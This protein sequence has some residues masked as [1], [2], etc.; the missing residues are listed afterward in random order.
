MKRHRSF[1]LR[2]VL[3]MQSIIIAIA[4]LAVAA[5]FL[6]F[7]EAPQENRKT[8]A[9]GQIPFEIENTLDGQTTL[10][11]DLSISLKNQPYMPPS[12]IRKKTRLIE[13][14]GAF[15]VIYLLGKNGQITPVFQRKTYLDKDRFSKN[16]SASIVQTLVPDTNTSEPLWSDAFISPVTDMPSS[17]CIIPLANHLLVGEIRLSRLTEILNQKPT[18][19][20]WVALDKHNHVVA[21]SGGIFE[22]S[23]LPLTLSRFQQATGLFKFKSHDQPETLRPIRKTSWSVFSVLPPPPLAENI[24][25][26]TPLFLLCLAT[27]IIFSLLFSF[28]FSR[29]LGRQL[30][31]YIKNTREIARGHSPA[32][33]TDAPIREMAHLSQNLRKMSRTIQEKG[34]GYSRAMSHYLD[35]IKTIENIT[36]VLSPDLVITYVNEASG[37]IFGLEPEKCLGRSFLEFVKPDNIETIKE[38]HDR[39]AKQGLESVTVEDK[40]IDSSG[41]AHTVLWNITLNRDENDVFTG[42]TGVG[43]EFS[44]WKNM[45]EELQ[46]A[47]LV[48]QKSSEGMIL[49]NEENLII[50]VNPAF[51]AITGYT[52]K[53]ALFSNLSMLGSALHDRLFYENIWNAMDVADHWQGEAWNMRKN[54]ERYAIRLTINTIRSP[55]NKIYR[56]VAFF[57][58][59]TEQKLAEKITRQQN[60]FDSLTGLPN[61]NFLKQELSRAKKINMPVALM[62]LALDGVRHINETFG[63]MTGNRL[64]QE[65]AQ[66]LQSG[67]RETDAAIR[68]GGDEFAI[69]LRNITNPEEVET[70]GKTILSGLLEAFFLNNT[71]IHISASIGITFYPD[72]ATDAD[73]LLKN[74][75][76][77]MDAAK[78]EGKNTLRY[79]T[80]PIQEMRQVR[81]QLINDLRQALAGRQFEIMYQPVVEI[82]SGLIHKAEAFIRWQHPVRRTINPAEFISIAEDSGII[83]SFGNWILHETATQVRIWRERFHPDFQVSINISPVHFKNEGIDFINW[84]TSL[85][86]LQLPGNGLVIEITEGLLMEKSDHISQQLATFKNAGME[87]ALDDFGVGSSSLSHLQNLNFNYLKIDQSFIRNLSQSN[88]NQ[89][90][91]E[92]IIVMA[93]KQ[94]LK[95]IAEG[96]ETVRQREILLE[97]AC[98]FAQ[99]YLY[100]P[101]LPAA[102]FELILENNYAL[103]NPD[104]LADIA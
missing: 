38:R 14:D 43:H 97:A 103:S 104:F 75:G 59:I 46:L 10:L 3:A 35:I 51:E 60:Y 9:I 58:D 69:L 89:A 92:A 64:L 53:E 40:L 1:S 4:P 94:H 22:T 76:Q 12:D 91:C 23:S 34:N 62:F 16:A 95:V 8:I 24:R 80:R 52:S 11:R 88:D 84:M 67:I 74:A 99:G 7:Q 78:R 86:E 49:F 63:H 48:Y 85:Q 44:A 32:I 70:I 33:Q 71:V 77:A 6:F 42:F 50:S 26:Y 83:A 27:G 66:R 57:S 30:L 82:E 65:T 73:D 79:F 2:N 28:F 45:Q 36:V 98:D 68:L 100:S 17:A 81:L 37:D 21:A 31:G 39:W 61:R 13:K 90:L 72:D 87:I 101:P 41:K 102:Q 20:I 96:I 15:D 19:L 47:A 93:H 56:R 54:G 25:Q 5:L 29:S 55:D 18:S